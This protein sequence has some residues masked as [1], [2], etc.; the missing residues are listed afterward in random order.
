MSVLWRPWQD[1]YRRRGLIRLMV[2]RDLVGRYK[3]SFAGLLWTVVNPLALL[4]IYWFVFA[5][6]LRIRFSTSG[7]P[8]DVVF[9]VLAGL[10]PWMAFAEAL[11][12]SN[13]CILENPNLVK[14]VVFPLEVLPINTT[15]SAAANSLVGIVLLMLLV[16]GH[17]GG[18]PWTSAL[19]PVILLPQLLLTA[20]FGWFLASLGVF[21]RDINHIIGLV[22]TIWMF[23][24]PIV[25]PQSLVPPSLLPLMRLNP[26]M[27]IVEGYRSVLLDGAPPAPLQWLYLLGISLL[28]FFLGYYWFIRTKRAFA[29]VI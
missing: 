22:L 21:I 13:T 11:V 16:L 18:L 28:M 23:L 10:L 6:I 1:L 24:C 9:Y 2:R 29:D 12:R 26:F 15:L 8:I 14:K 25:Y 27:A 4:F 20:G 5:F 19:L 3:G 17:R 7:E